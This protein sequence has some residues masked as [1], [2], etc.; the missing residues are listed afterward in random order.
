MWY[1]AEFGRSRSNVIG[2]DISVT[3]MGLCDFSRKSQNSCTGLFSGLCLQGSK[4]SNSS[5]EYGTWT[6]NSCSDTAYRVFHDGIMMEK[7]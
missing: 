1:P 4:S 7:W 2:T 3:T 5:M 6:W